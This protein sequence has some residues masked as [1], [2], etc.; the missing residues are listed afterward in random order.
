MTEEENDCQFCNADN[1]NYNWSKDCCCARFISHLPTKAI[2][3]AWLNH[4]LA[5][6]GEERTE[7]IKQLVSEAWDKHKREAM[8]LPT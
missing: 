1:G 5:E 3:V 6:F 7:Y 4:W 2:R 8:R